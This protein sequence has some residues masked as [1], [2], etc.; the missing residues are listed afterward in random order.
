MGAGSSCRG[1]CTV[2]HIGGPIPPGPRGVG[3]RSLPTPRAMEPVPGPA[4]T[5]LSLLRRDG[6]PPARRPGA[7]SRWRCREACARSTGGR[8][9]RGGAAGPGGRL[10]ADRLGPLRESSLA[11]EPER[12]VGGAGQLPLGLAGDKAPAHEAV[13][14][15]ALLG[16]GV[17]ALKKA[18]GALHDPA[19]GVGRVGPSLRSGRG[20]LRPSAAQRAPTRRLEALPLGQMGLVGGLWV[21]SSAASPASARM[22]ATSRAIC[23]WGAVG[24]QGGARGDPGGPRGPPRPGAPGRPGR[25]GAAPRR[26]SP[27]SRRRERGGNGRWWC[28]RAPGWR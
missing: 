25:T 3:S 20:G 16:L 5:L 11:E 4:H 10:C 27:P 13:H 7:S 23:S 17:V 19:V 22:C 14:A 28:G 18:L 6:A 1:R 24:G 21:A 2:A 26:S 15:A 12:G 8:R 9:D